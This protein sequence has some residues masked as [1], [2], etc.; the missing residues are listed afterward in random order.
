MIN[1]FPGGSFMKLHTAVLVVLTFV[2]FASP[3]LGAG[4]QEVKPSPTPV[5]IS[6]T[7][8]WLQGNQSRGDVKFHDGVVVEVEHLLEAEQQDKLN[9]RD[10]V[11]YLNGEPLRGVK[12]AGIESPKTE[13]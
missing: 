8:A 7:R 10:F 12:V 6:V 11:L 9:P 5:P 2:L 13:K 1:L 4:A 3:A